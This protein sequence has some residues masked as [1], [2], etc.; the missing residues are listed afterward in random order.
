MPI[1]HKIDTRRIKT[2]SHRGAA[3]SPI[4][5]FCLDELSIDSKN[6]IDYFAPTF[7]SLPYDP[8]D[9]AIQA[10][11]IMREEEISTYHE[12]EIEWLNYWNSEL[13]V[14]NE[15]NPGPNFWIKKIIDE[16]TKLQLLELK[17]FRRRSCF[18][19]RAQPTKKPYLWNIV[20]VGSPTFTQEV[21]DLRSRPR[22]FSLPSVNVYK[23]NRMLTLI[24][25]IAQLIYQV[26]GARFEALN[27][28][29][30]QML[31]YALEGGRLPAP[32]GFHQDGSDYI[33]SG[34]VM[35]RN[36]VSGGQSTVYYTKE[37]DIALQT[38]LQP[39]EGILQSDLFHDLWHRISPIEKINKKHIA[40]R[41]IIGLDINFTL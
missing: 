13:F 24:A 16:K 14:T 9:G 31:T 10:E 18:E 37:K 23:D 7:L 19:Y 26:S 32:E 35:E 33:V 40:Y 11:K 29:M 41:S 15:E 1:V 8:Y 21:L 25:L 22:R 39:Q 38:T 4:K 12:H 17:P 2:F 34:L 3:L 5:V 36:N 28:V 6:F 30:H 20:E 27:I